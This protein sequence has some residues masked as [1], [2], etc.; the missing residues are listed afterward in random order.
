MRDR[1]KDLPKEGIDFDAFLTEE[2]E[3]VLRAI[4][5][6][7]VQVRRGAGP[8]DQGSTSRKRARMTVPGP[9]GDVVLRPPLSPHGSP[10]L[11]E[12]P[13]ALM[14]LHGARMGPMGVHFLPAVPGYTIMHTFVP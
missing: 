8:D 1:L 11:V 5:V 2:R 6:S 9:R 10:H 14:P 3:E 12:F 4:A 13:G 7:A